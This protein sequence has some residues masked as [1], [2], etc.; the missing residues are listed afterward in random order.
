MQVVCELLSQHVLANY[1]KFVGGI[2]G[3]SAVEQDLQH[4]HAAVRAARG[5]LALAQVTLAG[6]QQC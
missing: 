4:A 5:T 2:D 3:V 1:S 6:Y